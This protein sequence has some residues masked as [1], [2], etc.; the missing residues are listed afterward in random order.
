M[1]ILHDTSGSEIKP[2]GFDTPEMAALCRPGGSGRGPVRELARFYQMLL[3]GGS[4]DG[5]RIVSPQTVEAMTAR[6][7]VGMFDQTFKH[8][9]DWG[10]GFIVNSNQYGAD[11]V[12]YGYG[13]HASWRTFGHSGYQSSVAFADPKNELAVAIVF[14]GTPGEA[15]HDRRVRGVLRGLY[16]DLGLVEN[17]ER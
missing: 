12:P 14:N 15:A 16:E 7:R 17:E 10:L 2:A 6:H 1:G 8:V 13:P 4:L 5:A 3:N 11:T 9:M